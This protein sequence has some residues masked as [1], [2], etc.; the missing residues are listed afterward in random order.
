MW[1]F[2]DKKIPLDDH[3]LSTVAKHFSISS[4]G[5]HDALSDVKITLLILREIGWAKL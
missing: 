4:E 5:A 3:K 2:L 1:W